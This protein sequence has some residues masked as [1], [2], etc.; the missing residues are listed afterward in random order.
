MATIMNEKKD[1]IITHDGT[2]NKGYDDDHD[3]EE[4]DDGAG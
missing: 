2:V 4:I 1:D 3:N